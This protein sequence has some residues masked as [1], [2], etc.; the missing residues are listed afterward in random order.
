M[1]LVDG[2]LF[3][4]AA[5][6]KLGNALVFGKWKGRNV[7]REYVVPAN[8]RSIA[9]RGRRTMM[10]VINDIWGGMSS[11]DKAS[12]EDLAIAK[13]Y[14]TF[15]GMTSY[16]LDQL[17]LNTAPTKN[18]SD[19]VGSV[20]AAIAFTSATGGTNRIDCEINVTT[21]QA[22]SYALVTLVEGSTVP[23]SGNMLI[24]VAWIPTDATGTFPVAITDL[25]A[26]T[27]SIGVMAVTETGAQDS[28]EQDSVPSIVVTGTA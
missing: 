24:A 1:A 9:Q 7:V 21:G 2:P 17:T 13:Q 14:S 26:G 12:W 6:G 22:G 19:S 15:N 18:R 8:P 3:S 11:S 27:Y 16:N 5:S 28:A 25:P 23:S 10:G 20:S 4:L